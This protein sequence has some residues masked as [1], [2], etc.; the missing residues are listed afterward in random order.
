MDVITMGDFSNTN[1]NGKTAVSFRIPSIKTIDYVQE[2]DEIKKS[3]YKHEGRTD[4]CPCESK[5]K[6]KNCH[7]RNS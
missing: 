1:Y 7:G 3:Q 4:L 2:A 6:F 5:M